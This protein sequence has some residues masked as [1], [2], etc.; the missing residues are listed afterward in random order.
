MIVSTAGHKEK[1]LSFIKR[2]LVRNKGIYIMFIPVLAYFVLFHYIPMYGAQ[3]AFRD[4]DFRFG[5]TGSKFIGLR[6]F[7]SFFWQQLFLAFAQEHSAA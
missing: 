3:I 1:K 7:V 2:D 5:I 4:F 6:H